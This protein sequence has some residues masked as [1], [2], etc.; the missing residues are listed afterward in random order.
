[1]DGR[2]ATFRQVSVVGEFRALWAAQALS[3]IGDQLAR[4]AVAILVFQRTRSPGL[5]AVAYAVTFLPWLVGGPLLAALADRFPRRRVMICTDLARA[6]LLSLMALPR[7]PIAAL[8]ALIFI[9][10]LFEPPFAA[11]RAALLPDILPDDRYVLASAITNIT[12][13]VA[14]L[15]GFAL[16]G[17]LVLLLHAPGALLLDAATFLL[18]ALILVLG[19]RPRPAAHRRAASLG[20]P[21]LAGGVRLVFGSSRLRALAGLAWLC[22]F[23]V[24]PEGL[25]APLAATTHAGPLA[26]GLLMAANPAGTIAGSVLISRLEP[27]RRLHWM[28]PLAVL[29]MAPL[30][31][32]AVHPSL[33]VLLALLA[34]SGLGSAYNLPANAAFVAAVPAQLRGRAFG[35]VQSGMY[36]GQ[37]L[38]LVVA[39]LLA[40]VVNPCTVVAVLGAAGLLVVARL[41]RCLQ[42]AALPAPRTERPLSAS[43]V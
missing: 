6:G 27:A 30:V 13:E 29:S 4:V 39:G 41:V 7:I 22:T 43:G 5:S 3:L 31:M 38:A 32:V 28:T 37:G 9:A 24:A 21:D 2:A 25:A 18:S 33:P 42:E 19:L 10:E 12:R 16:G 15:L 23:Y 11:A 1:M 26:V 20:G 8:L 34:L 35:V 40:Q 36:V 17:A 14:Q